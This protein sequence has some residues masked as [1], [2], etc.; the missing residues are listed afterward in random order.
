MKRVALARGVVVSNTYKASRAIAPAIPS[1]L[2]LPGWLLAPAWPAG[3][4]P[5]R[6][7]P[8]LAAVAG[9]SGVPLAASIKYTDQWEKA[10]VL[11]LGRYCGLRGPGTRYH[12]DPDRL[13]TRSISGSGQQPS[14]PNRASTR[15]TVPGNVDAIAFWIVRDA[16]RAALEVQDYDEAVILSPRPLF[17]LASA[18]T[19]WPS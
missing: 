13:P 16:E 6:V 15:D 19:T 18:N 12:P 14:A 1:P 17:E 4:I 5:H 8:P 9:G 2:S 10:V 11:R 3:V 7:A